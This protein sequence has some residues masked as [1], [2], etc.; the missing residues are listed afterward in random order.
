MGLT[1]PLSIGRAWPVALSTGVGIGM[2]YADC[3][4]SFG[5]PRIPGTRVIPPKQAPVQALGTNQ[6]HTTTPTSAVVPAK[7]TPK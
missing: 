6:T 3:E 5:M 7:E 1:L 4:R 2:S